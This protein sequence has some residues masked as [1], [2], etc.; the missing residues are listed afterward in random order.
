MLAIV[1]SIPPTLQRKKMG[2]RENKGIAQSLT[3]DRPIAHASCSEFS[4][5]LYLIKRLD[6][7]I[8][9]PFHV[10]NFI[11]FISWDDAQV[12]YCDAK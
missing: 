8:E 10:W 9:G 3:A 2:S 6:L 7:I 4:F 12:T 1:S 5:L 11:L